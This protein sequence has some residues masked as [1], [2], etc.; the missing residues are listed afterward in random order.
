MA[1]GELGT[2]AGAVGAVAAFAMRLFLPTPRQTN[3]VLL[4]GCAVFGGALYLR[5]L[6]IEAP[7]IEAACASAL[8][9]AICG[10]RRFALELSDMELFGGLALAAA[11]LHFA[12]PR[13]SLFAGGV[14]AAIAGLIL[15]NTGPAALAVALLVVSLSRPVHASRR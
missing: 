1:K 4:L 13:F 15:Y 12:R 9:R 5:H 8:P 10:V 3:L 2:V 6:V 11:A 7:A 14:V